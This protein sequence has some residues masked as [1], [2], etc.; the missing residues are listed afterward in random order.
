[1]RASSIRPSGIG[2][3]ASGHKAIKELEKQGH[4]E[5]AIEKRGYPEARSLSSGHRAGIEHQTIGYQVSSHKAIKEQEVIE[6]IEQRPSR[7]EAIKKRGHQ[8]AAIEN[9]HQG[10]AIEKRGH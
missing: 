3:R 10:A 8:K 4:R 6:V 2:H 5:V 9:G 7:S 1:M